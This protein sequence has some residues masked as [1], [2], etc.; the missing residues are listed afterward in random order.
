MV[1]QRALRRQRLINEYNELMSISGDVIHVEPLGNTHP[2]EKYRITFHLRT[3][4]SDAPA[5]RDKT[6]CILT[7]PAGYPDIVPK[8]A[9]EETSMPQPWHPNWYRSGTWCFG[10]W[11]REESLVN[12]VYRCAK[13]IQFDANFTA[14]TE[15]DAAN[16]E[17]LAF[18]NS[19]KGKRGIIPSD[20]KKLPTIDVNVPAISIL[21]RAKPKITI[22]R[23]R[24]D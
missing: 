13:T 21:S 12:Y 15:K 7:I 5:F 20:T 6:V 10:F 18:W 22:L 23:G 8:I 9:V 19:N 11:T 14:A 17:A 24:G 16:K 2:Y 3:V 1:D 4:I